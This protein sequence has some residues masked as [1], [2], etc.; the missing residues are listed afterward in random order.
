MVEIPNY[1][2]QRSLGAHGYSMHS[3]KSFV[4]NNAFMDAVPIPTRLFKY[5]IYFIY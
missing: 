2:M 1:N 3:D 4:I 5:S